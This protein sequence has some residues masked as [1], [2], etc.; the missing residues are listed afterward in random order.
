MLRLHVASAVS[1][2]AQLSRISLMRLK[3]FK[4]LETRTTDIICDS[5][6]RSQIVPC[7]PE[8]Q[9]VSKNQSDPVYQQEK[10]EPCPCPTP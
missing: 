6:Q 9:L 7:E 3:N 1:S 4:I 2:I 8:A 5:C 10:N